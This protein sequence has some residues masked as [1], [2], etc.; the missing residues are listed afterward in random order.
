MDGMEWM[1]WN[2]VEW[3]DRNGM[4]WEWNGKHARI[5]NCPRPTRAT[6]IFFLL[7][8]QPPRFERSN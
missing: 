2:G 7:L 5:I 6:F 1:E 8:Q 3:N 4:G